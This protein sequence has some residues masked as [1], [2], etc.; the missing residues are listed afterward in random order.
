M[1]SNCK[2]YIYKL[3]LKYG[4]YA[5]LA[6]LIFCGIAT[7]YAMLDA[8]YHLSKALVFKIEE[9]ILGNHK[10]I[11]PSLTTTV[12]SSCLIFLI[13]VG[14]W[15]ASYQIYHNYKYKAEYNYQLALKKQNSTKP[16]PE[17]K[18]ISK[19]NL[20]IGCAIILGHNLLSFMND[21][22]SIAFQKA[23]SEKVDLFF[24][25]AYSA[26]LLIVFITSSLDVVQTGAIADRLALVLKDAVKKENNKKLSLKERLQKMNWKEIGSKYGVFALISLMIV[27]SSF[28][29]AAFS[30]HCDWINF[31]LPPIIIGENKINWFTNQQNTFFLIL[32]PI[33]LFVLAY[34]YVL[35]VLEKKFKTQEKKEEEN[36]VTSNDQ[37]KKEEENAVTSNDQEKKNSL[38]NQEKK[39]T[40]DHCVDLLQS[41]GLSILSAVSIDISINV[42]NSLQELKV[43]NG[44][45]A[46]CLV[47][48]FI[49]NIISAYC[50]VKQYIDP[51]ALS[52]EKDNIKLNK[53]KGNIKPKIEYILSKPLNNNELA[54]V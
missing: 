34:K 40:R 18:R 4:L 23:I 9:N 49:V 8:K 12:F 46:I 15:I 50:F 25:L 36:A 27:F 48:L 29:F 33:L 6:G 35:P 7:V 41:I 31:D 26:I 47:I 22:L 44:A 20:L 30:K 53:E 28:G 1:T 14:G 10:F 37:E 21:E 11:F 52:E 43:E 45:Y 54:I 17:K 13:V 39:S 38:I 5:A 16:M 32:M 24:W 3:R 19:K 2:N 42:S 51:P